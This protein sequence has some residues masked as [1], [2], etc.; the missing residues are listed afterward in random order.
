MEA[1]GGVGGR[2]MPRFNGASFPYS[3]W[4][5]HGHKNMFQSI[6]DPFLSSRFI[7]KCKSAKAVLL[8]S[9]HRLDKLAKY[10]VCDRPC[11]ARQKMGQNSKRQIVKLD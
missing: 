11:Y 10:L 5:L 7:S 6:I 4:K 2:W 3:S 9:L 1:L 8:S